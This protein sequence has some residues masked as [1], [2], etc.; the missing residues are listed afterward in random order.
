MQAYKAT[1]NSDI[2][3]RLIKESPDIFAYFILE[4]LN[5]S[6]SQSVFPSALK[7]AN[8]TPVKKKIQKVKKIITGTSVFYQIFLKIYEKFL[9]KQISEYF[10]QFLY[11]F[12]CGFTVDNK[13]VFGVLLTDFSKIFD[14]LL[15]DL[16]IA[17]LNEMHTDLVWQL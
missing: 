4:N 1:Q 9:F 7:L 13:K 8:T 11:I 14:C 17:K 16:L 2:P 5:Y 15:H 10:K 12:H 6:I 3:A